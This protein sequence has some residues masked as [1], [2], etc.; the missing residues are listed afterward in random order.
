MN[1]QNAHDATRYKIF[2]TEHIMIF[3][4]IDKTSQYYNTNTSSHKY[5]SSITNNIKLFTIIQNGKRIKFIYR[6]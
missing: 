3:K 1:L 5:T 2:Q 4:G 6:E